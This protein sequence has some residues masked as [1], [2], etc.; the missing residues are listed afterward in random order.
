[1]QQLFKDYFRV[2]TPEVVEEEERGEEVNVHKIWDAFERA[3]GEIQEEPQEI[4]GDDFWK[5]SGLRRVN[6]K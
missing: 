3:T 4:K 5:R 1:L 2:A 6:K